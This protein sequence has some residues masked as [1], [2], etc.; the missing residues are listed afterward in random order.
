MR[1]SRLVPAGLAALLVASVSVGS[2]QAAPPDFFSDPEYQAL[3]AAATYTSGLTSY[4]GGV[5][6]SST[7]TFKE[8]SLSGSTISTNLEVGFNESDSTFGSKLVQDYS[9]GGITPQQVDDSLTASGSGWGNFLH[10]AGLLTPPSLSTATGGGND[11]VSTTPASSMDKYELWF[12][13]HYNWGNFINLHKNDIVEKKALRLLGA[14]KAKFAVG[15]MWDAYWVGDQAGS[16]LAD[17][18]SVSPASVLASLLGETAADPNIILGDVTAEAGANDSTIYSVPL[19]NLSDSSEI[20]VVVFT[21][22]VDGVLTTVA[23]GM[24]DESFDASVS[25]ELVAWKKT[26]PVVAQPNLNDKVVDRA[27]LTATMRYLYLEEAVKGTARVVANEA[28]S[29]AMVADVKV[30][31]SLIR[32]VAKQMGLPNGSVQ[33]TNIRKG[34]ALTLAEFPKGVKCKV[35]AEKRKGGWQAVNRCT[36]P[37]NFNPLPGFA[38]GR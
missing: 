23:Y 34:V 11:S 30:S 6:S 13:Y 20:L 19:L 15:W 3:A 22:N 1:I 4:W 31:P 28:N 25:N 7:I 2:A 14:P 16:V 37:K 32:R 5:V 33:V 24:N 9:R 10:K 38:V 17:F 26:D 18:N 21:V 36:S 35:T 27:D 29:I 8:D 12:G